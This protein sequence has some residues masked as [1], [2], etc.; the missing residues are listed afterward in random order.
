MATFHRPDCSSSPDCDGVEDCDGR[1]HQC[2]VFGLPGMCQW[3]VSI[4]MDNF[5]KPFWDPATEAGLAERWL[6]GTDG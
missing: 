4:T 6:R 5:D 1:T 2:P 3:P